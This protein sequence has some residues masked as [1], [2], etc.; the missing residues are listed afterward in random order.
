MKQFYFIF[1]L[2]A[3]TAQAQ[4][5]VE[6]VGDHNIPSR[7]F[8]IEQT[9][10]VG[11]IHVADFNT[12]G[13]P[14]ILVPSNSFPLALNDGSGHF[15]QDYSTEIDPEN[16]CSAVGDIDGDGD[17]DFI[18]TFGFTQLHPDDKKMKIY[19]NDGQGHFTLDENQVFQGLSD[20]VLELEDLDQD[21]D[22]DIFHT[23]IYN[24][25][26]LDSMMITY[27]FI[28]DGSGEFVPEFQ[29]DIVPM[30][31]GD[32][33]IRDLSGDGAPEIIITGRSMIDSAG[34]IIIVDDSFYYMND[35]SGN[36]TLEESADLA[37][38]MYSHVGIV[39]I[40]QDND[41]DLVL[42]SEEDGNERQ[43]F[44]YINDGSGSFTQSVELPVSIPEGA[45]FEFEDIDNNGSVDMILMGG[46]I[47]S[48][49]EYAI[50]V[51]I[52]TGNYV[53]EATSNYTI[54]RKLNPSF[55]LQDI[56]NDGHPD[57]ILPFD[58]GVYYNDGA[59]HFDNEYLWFK[60]LNQSE[61]EVIDLNGD[62]YMDMIHFGR[63]QNGR[64]LANIH[65][66]TSTK[67]FEY[68]ETIYEHDSLAV[69]D[70][71]AVHLNEDQNLDL[72]ILT[73]GESTENIHY[74]INQDNQTFSEVELSLFDEANWS[75]IIAKDL[76][77]DGQA[78]IILSGTDANNEALSQI[79]QGM[80]EGD[81]DKVKTLSTMI[82]AIETLNIDDDGILDF[83]FLGHNIFSTF[84]YK[85]L[86]SKGTSSWDNFLEEQELLSSA[87]TFP[88]A[89]QA[90][91]V[92]EDQNGLH[93]L[94]NSNKHILFTQDETGAF[95]QEYTTA[96][97]PFEKSLLYSGDLNDDGMADYLYSFDE[98]EDY[99]SNSLVNIVDGDLLLMDSIFAPQRNFIGKFIFKHASADFDLDG[100]LDAL[101]LQ[102]N[103]E[104]S[105]LV[106]QRLEPNAIFETAKES[107]FTLFPNP[108]AQSSINIQLPEDWQEEKHFM[109]F[110]Q[111]GRL[112][113]R[114][115]LH[116]AGQQQQ[117]E[118][119]GRQAGLYSI[120]IYSKNRKS[121]Q[122]FL[123]QR[124]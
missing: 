16:Y 85:L 87:A 95:I 73:E 6:A 99:P 70:I 5:L 63:D 120:L 50:E 72:L 7:P 103:G 4:L 19:L 39:D 48:Q 92:I 30:C 111:S 59:G 40:D 89:Y 91:N 116:D 47:L 71:A 67:S 90:I 78:D 64:E 23:G 22:L 118:L 15:F 8:F 28:N 97:S 11:E 96:G 121:S 1:L 122:S 41:N 42:L 62:S 12:D 104:L 94:L 25:Y 56:N 53:F 117:I 26:I 13:F 18:A 20:G 74:F 36:F 21:G 76:N 123:L 110:D 84:T 31:E 109:I 81:F 113:Q 32:I 65:L 51:L 2:F 52:N 49:Q 88:N 68:N 61:F 112:V 44:L 29:T 10:E 119:I 93:I 43:A 124:N 86:L 9:G 27:I 83:A 60:D 69:L 58:S 57:L 106:N 107:S 37:N 77:E 80:N 115:V 54:A 105:Y 102:N 100:D 114:G 108:T 55:E 34:T 24:Q 14:D 46:S 35:G 101:I 75:S 17:L 38:A 79:Y 45:H 82:A 3:S 33:G 66:N 98:N